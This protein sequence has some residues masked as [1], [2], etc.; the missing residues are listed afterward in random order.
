[1]NNNF[2]FKPWGELEWLFSKTVKSNFDLIASL[3]P[4]D[5]CTSTFEICRSAK[6][7]KSALFLEIIDPID[8]KGHNSLRIKNKNKIS[9]NIDVSFSTHKLLEPISGL[10][11]IVNNFIDNSDGNIIVDISTFPKRFFFLIIKSLLKSSKV[12]TLFVTCSTPKKYSSGNLSDNPNS[13]TH[14][15]TFVPD[16]PDLRFDLAI[17]GIGFMPLGLPQLL[18]DK[19]SQLTTK[20]LFP[21]PPGPPTYQ[22][23]WEFVNLMHS[24]TRLEGKQIYRVDSLNLPEIFETIV[25]LT[26]AGEKSTLL[27]PYGPKTM[28]LAMCL[29]ACF[30]NSAVY[31]TQPTYYAP[32]YSSGFSNCYG[33]IIK[34][35]DTLFY[36]V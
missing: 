27:A 23:T 24:S 5:R 18:K 8:T 32:D 35:N 3:S 25:S 14:I 16:D 34:S 31:Y 26:Q 20:Y 6:R 17:I 36:S 33:Y 28:S 2:E 11:R 30:T 13:W 10:I 22:R 15:P 4:E 19:Y 21:F 7:I 29:Y 1:M 12:K 9:G